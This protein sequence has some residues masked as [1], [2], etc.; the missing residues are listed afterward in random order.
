MF[1]FLWPYLV[2]A[3]TIVC[4][5]KIMSN[6]QDIHIS[7]ET[8]MI[9]ATELGEILNVGPAAINNIRNRNNLIDGADTVAAKNGRR[10]Y[11]PQ[12]IK[13]ILEH[14]G[15]DFSRKNISVCN[16]KGGVGKTTISVNLARKI[17]TLGF[18]T[19]LVDIDKQ[20]NATDQLWPE[21]AETQFPCLLDVIEGSVNLKDTIIPISDTLSLLPSN[22]KNQ[23]LDG[24]IVEKG[25]NQGTFFSRHMDSLDY[26]V[27]IFDTEPNLS[28]VNLMALA[29]SS[30]NIAPVR[31]DKNSIDG[32]DLLLGFIE[33][34]SKEWPNMQLETKAL[35]NCF[36]QR[37]L[38]TSLEKIADL[39]QIGVD[40]FN[41][42][43]R[44]D[45]SFVKA[46]DSQTI[47]KSTKAY[48]DITS[49]TIELL[50]LGEALQ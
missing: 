28:K 24:K 43:L 49:L 13:K 9:Q 27:V 10:Y 31:L 1:I 11:T 40:A 16:V 44:T 15:Y 8:A 33:V 2:I 23:L 29:Y 47:K 36:D 39:K 48:E 21:G 26:D 14:K 41:T 7:M 6:G 35:I 3:T 12:G 46:Q 4:V 22:L 38:K 34:Q 25:I 30:L 42:A 17:S 18:K 32:L 50:G 45:T 20:G 19:L 37:M 5:E